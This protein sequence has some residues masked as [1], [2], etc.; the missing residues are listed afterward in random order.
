[1]HREANSEHLD[2]SANVTIWSN[3]ESG[4][5]IVAASIPPLRRLFHCLRSTIGS[6]GRSKGNSHSASEHVSGYGKGSRFQ[7]GAKDRNGVQLDSLKFGITSSVSGSA[8]HR[9]KG[10]GKYWERMRDDEEN[11]QS[12]QKKIIH[13]TAVKVDSESFGS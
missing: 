11:S 7:H 6:S 3:V 10:D 5:G 2:Y 4:V 12:S 9:A 13:S 8:A 1:L